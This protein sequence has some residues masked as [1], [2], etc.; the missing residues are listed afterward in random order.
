VNNATIR[1]L[2]AG[3]ERDKA[4]KNCFLLRK[5][6]RFDWD[7]SNISNSILELVNYNKKIRNHVI[8][9]FESTNRWYLKKKVSQNNAMKKS[10]LPILFATMHRLSELA[11]YDPLGLSRHY[12]LQHNWLLTEFL[13]VAP[14]QYIY[15]IA[16]EVTG[17]EFIRPYA[18][19]I[20]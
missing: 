2:P 6:K 15:N 1:I 11:R 9:I 7:E 19:R 17:K 3:Y 16:C 10:L 4:C 20:K 5:K 12:D 14:A 18:F 13:R 8:P